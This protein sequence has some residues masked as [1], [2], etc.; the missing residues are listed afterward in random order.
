MPLSIGL[1]FEVVVLS[2]KS[3]AEIPPVCPSTTPAHSECHQRDRRGDQSLHA[4][5]THTWFSQLH[6]LKRRG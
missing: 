1:E 2:L 3:A 4:H 6:Y 5:V